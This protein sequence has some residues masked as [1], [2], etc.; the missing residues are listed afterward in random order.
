LRSA[1]PIVA[2]ALRRQWPSAAPR[3]DATASLAEEADLVLDAA[4]AGFC[5]DRLSTRERMVTQ[6][7]LRGHSNQSVATLLG[8]AESTVKNHRKS[9]YAKLAIA[10]QQELFSLFLTHAL[11]RRTHWR[12]APTLN[13][14]AANLCP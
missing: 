6:M 12:P 7:V 3:P 9:I 2:A 10:S 14:P 4:F 1:E 8:I 13:V 11:D 5:A